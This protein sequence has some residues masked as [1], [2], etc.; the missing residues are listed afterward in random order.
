MTK[1][2]KVLLY[3]SCCRVLKL[4]LL[5]SGNLVTWSVVSGVIGRDLPSERKNSIGDCYKGLWGNVNT[6]CGV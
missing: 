4:P 5:T 6:R 2:M 3:S 1:V